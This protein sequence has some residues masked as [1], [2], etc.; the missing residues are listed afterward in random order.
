[1]KS[2]IGSGS[3]HESIRVESEAIDATTC[4]SSDFTISGFKKNATALVAQVLVLLIQRYYQEWSFGLHKEC[5]ILQSGVEIDWF[6]CKQTRIPL[7]NRPDAIRDAT[8]K[9]I[10]CHC[11]S[12]T[13]PSV[14][15]F[16]II[17][18]AFS[19]CFVT[20]LHHQF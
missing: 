12:R 8:S 16:D 4:L 13:S 7:C 3:S 17:C 19:T 2:L 9:L 15:T 6:Q 10:S 14:L 1:M 11:Y 20:T 18:N 5:L